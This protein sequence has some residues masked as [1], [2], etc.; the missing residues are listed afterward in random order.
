V[1]S[2]KKAVLVFLLAACGAGPEMPPFVGKWIS[3]DALV[4][5]AMV[6]RRVG[7]RV[8]GEFIPYAVERT[9]ILNIKPGGTYGS[10]ILHRLYGTEDMGWR[11]P[12]DE[13]YWITWRGRWY[14][15]GTILR[16]V[17]ESVERWGRWSVYA[18]N[19]Y[20]VWWERKE[21]TLVFLWRDDSGYFSE[22]GYRRVYHR[23]EE[24]LPVVS[25][26]KRAWGR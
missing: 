1:I 8:I 14:Q 13:T 22:E 19:E 26:L 4:D 16:F 12:F 21:D 11:E 3:K 17:I 6:A 25:L 9:Y 18:G 10:F 5:T 24:D 23:L 15:S 2:L 7:D 20:S